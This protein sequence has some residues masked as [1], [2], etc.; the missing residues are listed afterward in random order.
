M[1]TIF[2]DTLVLIRMQKEGKKIIS[3]Q[4]TGYGICCWITYED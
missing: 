4:E 2:G 1:K 3:V